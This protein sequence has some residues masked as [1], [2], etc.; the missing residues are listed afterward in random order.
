M[1]LLLFLLNYVETLI[2]IFFHLLISKRINL[3]KKISTITRVIEIIGKYKKL[4]S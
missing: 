1:L 2:I 3:K 4:Y